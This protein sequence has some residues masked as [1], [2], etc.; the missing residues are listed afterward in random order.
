MST[1]CP[2]C[3]QTIGLDAD[4]LLHLLRHAKPKHKIYRARNGEW[5]VTYGGGPVGEAV[6]R[7]LVER[8]LIRRTYSNY[9]DSYQVGPTIDMEA[10]QERRKREGR[11]A[12]LVYVGEALAPISS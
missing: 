8:K 3:G 5:Y 2:T 11:K 10:T 1:T 7:S 6:V 12:P 9:E 4:K